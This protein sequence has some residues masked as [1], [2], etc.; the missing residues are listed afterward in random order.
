MN[1]ARQT[2]LF[3]VGRDQDRCAA[4]SET[5]ADESPNIR[6]WRFRCIVDA[7]GALLRCRPSA[8]PDAVVLAD[9]FD[10]WVRTRLWECVAARRELI[11]VPVF[12]FAGTELERRRAAQRP[13]RAVDWRELSEPTGTEGFA[14]CARAILDAIG[15]ASD[16]TLRDAAHRHANAPIAMRAWQ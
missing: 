15:Y 10:D 13:M 9:P 12:A 7:G 16:A 4:I 11:A 3:L 1:K 6:L 8:I 2:N 14:P 5:V